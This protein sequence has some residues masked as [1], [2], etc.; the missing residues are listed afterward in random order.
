MTTVDSIAKERPIR[1]IKIDTEGYEL[2][3]SRGEAKRTINRDRPVISFE[4]NLTLLALMPRSAWELIGSC[5]TSY[6][7]W[8]IGFINSTTQ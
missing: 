1:L 4:I 8:V 6:R 5:S 7:P 3:V 2:E